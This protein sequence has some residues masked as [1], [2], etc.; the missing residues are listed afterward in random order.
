[1]V[2]CVN[3]SCSTFTPKFISDNE[4]N[5]NFITDTGYNINFNGESL[6]SILFRQSNENF[7]Y[8]IS[9]QP[10]S[11][12][13]DPEKIYYINFDEISITENPNGY[14]KS[15]IYLFIG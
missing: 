2:N 8:K 9:G 4:D 13:S 14:G 12:F 6:S 10:N 1:M 15:L 7:Q 5:S 3:G 11:A